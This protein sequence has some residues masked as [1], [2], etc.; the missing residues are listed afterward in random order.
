ML[1]VFKGD[2]SVVPAVAENKIFS[3]TPAMRVVSASRYAGFQVAYAVFGFFIHFS[4]LLVVSCFIN[5]AVLVPEIYEF[6]KD[7]A[8]LAW[9]VVV[10][11]LSLT[12][13]QY[14][15]ARFVFLQDR[16][17]VF[18]LNNRFSCVRWISAT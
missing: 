13:I 5:L 15:L 10:I 17:R 12:L 3:I 14:L 1:S 16:G 9:P 18:A 4:V 2:H 7:I 8:L 6:L 11:G